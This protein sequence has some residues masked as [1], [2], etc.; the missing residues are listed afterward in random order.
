MRALL[1]ITSN[2]TFFAIARTLCKQHFQV[3]VDQN[4]IDI[5]N[6]TSAVHE[7]LGQ[8]IE[9]QHIPV[10]WKQSFRNL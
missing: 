1:G 5:Q 6:K 10:L 9:H 8:F 2:L 4:V 7:T 3:M